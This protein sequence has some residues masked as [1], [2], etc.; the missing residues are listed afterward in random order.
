MK[1]KF[2][3]IKNS[4]THKILLATKFYNTTITIKDLQELNPSH[5]RLSDIMRSL[6]RLSDAGYV[7][8]NNN[9]SWIITPSGK[10]FLYDFI[11]TNKKSNPSKSVKNLT[12]YNKNK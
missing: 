9:N 10:K 2:V 3:M 5:N 6:K 4:L 1:S 8:L 7:I 11:E 12:Q